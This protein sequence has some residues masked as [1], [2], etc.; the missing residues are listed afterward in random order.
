MKFNHQ[1]V[2]V[3]KCHQNQLRHRY[4]SNVNS[5]D[6]DSLLDD[7]L[8]TSSK[9]TIATAPTAQPSKLTSP[10]YLRR[11]RRSPDRYTPTRDL[12]GEM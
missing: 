7:L 3:T 5:S 12:R 6:I 4:S 9:P 11:N 1:M 8:E 2:N 10:R